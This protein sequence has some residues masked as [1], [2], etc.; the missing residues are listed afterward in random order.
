VQDSLVIDRSS[1]GG[2][3]Q[4]EILIKQALNHAGGM[5]SNYNDIIKVI[6]PRSQN[7]GGALLQLDPYGSDYLNASYKNGNDGNLYKLELIYYPTATVDGNVQSLKVPQ[8]D[9]VIGAD[10][11]DLGSDKENYRYHYL[12]SNNRDRDD[13]SD[14]MAVAKAFSL[15]GAALDAATRQ[16]LD[17]NEWMRLFALQALGGVGDAYG[18]GNPHNLKLYTRPTDGKTMAL[19]WDWDFLFTRGATSSIYGDSNLAKV[20]ALPTNKHLYLGNMQDILATTFNT[21]YMSRWITHYGSLAGQDY[22]T[23]LTYIGNRASYALGQLPPQIAFSIASPN[24]QTVNQPT[25]TLT[26]KGWVNVKDIYAQGSTTPL[27]VSWSGTNVD[28][29]T[30]VAPV[31]QGANHLVLLAYDFQGKLIGTQSIDVTSTANLPNL[32][33]N[34][35]VTELNY[36]PAPPEAGSPYTAQ[37]FEFIELKNFGTQ[38]LNLKDAHFTSGITFTFGDVSLAPGEVGLVVSNLAAFGSRYG[39]GAKILGEYGASNTNFD[40]G[41]EEVTLVDS[42]NQGVVDF[43]YDDDPAA[44]WYAGADGGGATLEVVTP[45]VNADLSAPASWRASPLTDGGSPGVDDTLPA[46]APVGFSA[47][48]LGDQVKLSWDKVSG[49]WSYT[50]YRST[51]PGGEGAAPLASGL[52]G[53]AYADLTATGGQTYYYML[54]ATTPGGEGPRSAEALAHAHMPG[55]ANDDLS[56]DFL[57]LAVLAQNYNGGGGQSWARGDFNGDGRI[58]FLD[59]AILAQNYNTTRAA[60]A[61]A[62]AAP[63]TS[64][65]VVTAPPNIAPPPKPVATVPP[66]PVKP[67]AVAKPAPKPTAKP[68]PIARSAHSA[69]MMPVTRPAP[70]KPTLPPPPKPIFGTQRIAAATARKRDGLFDLDRA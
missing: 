55:D 2:G 56:D 66:K 53:T 44:G 6:A 4:S 38:T 25:I 27:S 34:L 59:L 36:N 49:A 54:S 3:S 65:P 40:N 10:L 28:T 51:T 16:L 42:V 69:V 63:E 26:G 46:A 52:T 39:T 43:T 64:A 50:L 37:D 35:R 30:A 18:Q 60:P 19:Q 12:L 14:I 67:V 58:D 47:Q 68:A 70:P 41:G 31:Y 13:F 57:D 24:N 1:S 17:V 62:A 8:N 7:T 45:G 15:T 29:W 20:T 21:T 32:P 33:A 23:D 5:P 48:A 22:S 9:A 11:G 61:G